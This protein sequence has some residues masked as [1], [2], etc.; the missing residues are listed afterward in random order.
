[1]TQC[2]VRENNSMRGDG[3]E[4]AVGNIRNPYAVQPQ[5]Q[6]A[7]QSTRMPATHVNEESKM[8]KMSLPVAAVAGLSMVACATPGALPPTNVAAGDAPARFTYPETPVLTSGELNPWR[9]AAGPDSRLKPAEW[10]LRFKDHNF[11]P[12]CY[13]TLE[14]IVV[15]NGFRFGS[16]SKPTRSSASYGD[17][18]LDGWRGSYSAGRSAPTAAQVTWRSKDGTSHEATIDMGAIFKGRLVRHFVPREELADLLHGEYT[19]DPSI[20]LEVNDRTIRVYMA[21]F[22]PTKHLQKPGNVWSS[23]RHDLV[24]VETYEF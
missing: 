5:P 11:G 13:D 18:Y 17:N 20:L 23:H 10:P 3:M 1:M 15:Y 24:L 8:G 16:Y 2:Y 9:V 22:L 7:G 12:R 21:A 4:D 14:C 6:V 19:L